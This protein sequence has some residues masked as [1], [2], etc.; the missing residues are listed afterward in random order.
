MDYIKDFWGKARPTETSKTDWHPLAYHSLD[1]AAAMQALLQ[2]RPQIL[3]AIS[4]SCGLG[5][6]ETLRQLVLV[7]ALHDIGKFAENFQC[8]VPDLAAR[9]GHQSAPDGAQ[10]WATD[11]HGRVGYCLWTEHYARSVS[12]GFD[13]WLHAAFSHHGTPVEDGVK[14]SNVMSATSRQ[15][16]EDFIKAVMVLLGPASSQAHD[17]TARTSETWR[18][19]G[20]VT[21]ADWIGSNVEN[22]WFPY[23]DTA[24]TL[25]SYWPR[26]CAKAKNALGETRLAE[27]MAATA[28]DLS[29]YL[30]PEAQATPLQ[31]W[32]Q[33]QAP[34]AGPNL[35]IIEDLTGAGKTEAALILANRL[36]QG[37]A[38]EGLYWA[39][40]SMAT[41]NG[42]YERVRQGYRRLFADGPEAS[43]VLAHSA[44]DL[45][46]GFQASLGSGH[47]HP[48]LKGANELPA[49][50]HCAAFV[51]ED[52]KKTFLAQIGVGTVDQALLA[53]LPVRHQALR[54]AALSRRVLVID[55]AHSFD[56][57][58]NKGLEALIGF[59]TALGG[60]TIILS[61]TLTQKL[62]G[63]F[64]KAFGAPQPPSLSQAFPLVTHINSEKVLIEQ[65][66]D[67]ARGTRRDLSI[68]RFDN[69]DSAMADLLSKASEGACAV[70][71]RNTV[72]D[73]MTAFHQLRAAAPEGVTVHLFHARFT[74][75][76]RI[77]RENRVLDLLGKQ[78]TPDTRRG[79]IIIATQVVEQS[80]DLDADYMAT[81][82]CPIDLL[83]QRAGRLHRHD[84]PGRSEP[85]L[86]LVGPQANDDAT[87][88]WYSALFPKG[89]Y[90]YPNVGQLWRTMRVITRA[91][92]L[93]L[94]S[95]SPRDL[96][97]P[98]FGDDLDIPPT[99]EA[100]SQ[101]AESQGQA[102]SAVA[103]LNFLD[104]T[105]GFERG[106]GA[107]D[108]DTRTPTRLGEPTLTLRLAKWADG[109]LAPWATAETPHLRW[110]L[111]EI[112]IRGGLCAETLAP[113]AVCEQAIATAQARWPQRYDPPPIL[114]MTARE[115]SVW[116][117][118]IRD[119]KGRERVATYST[120]GG[121]TL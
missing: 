55:E 4:R 77:S 66:V 25:E 94:Q 51:A 20:L 89:Q 26:A 48:G 74:L 18:V 60:S 63:R 28:F 19:A 17:K 65:P 8:K 5:R 88:T 61:A 44:R 56:P 30:G 54:L 64:I 41:A 80:L 97:E 90:V 33:A 82:L 119:Q 72:A 116:H 39:L 7:A 11:D 37:G 23:E 53:V 31:A 100:Q 24:F 22:D 117:G 99:L 50:A 81:D 16:V 13:L 38:A 101:K 34:S 71:V 105:Q 3:N 57:Y 120:L 76:D 121:L 12:K 113:D 118:R 85:Q 9:L 43:L 67:V 36:M 106:R 29:T 84:R 15:A 115:D 87:E 42:L 58:M 10:A 112:T 47:V 110:R 68:C 1:V 103:R 95:G 114:A 96:I 27:A 92:G 45:N 46:M 62:K 78:S 91:G 2:L 79:Q 59:H 75:G 40:P 35:Y 69:P 98:V 86:W 111:S 109:V 108:S 21:L 70:Y 52:R 104:P 73:A 32:A 14:L 107:W 6:D 102:D 93:M 83:I 49:E